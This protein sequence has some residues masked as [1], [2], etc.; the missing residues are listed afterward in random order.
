MVTWSGGLFSRRQ[1]LGGV[2]AAGAALVLPLPRGGP[3]V[4]LGR[5]LPSAGGAR[6]ADSAPVPAC[7]SDDFGREFAG[8]RLW[9]WETFNGVRVFGA[10]VFGHEALGGVELDDPKILRG[11]GMVVSLESRGRGDRASI[12]GRMRTVDSFS[13]EAGRRYLLEFR[14]AGSHLSG[15]PRALDRSIEARVPGVGATTTVRLPCSAGFRPVRLEFTPS[16]TT[17]SPIEFASCGAPGYGGLLLDSVH[18]A[19]AA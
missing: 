3:S 13:F 7:F 19:E 4:G 18:L 17:E 2:G 9:R 15:P 12:A 11:R 14:V 8:S 6:R 16:R 1:F 10:T 5:V